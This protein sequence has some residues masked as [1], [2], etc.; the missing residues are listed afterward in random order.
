MWSEIR[1]NYLPECREVIECA[2]NNEPPQGKPCGIF[3]VG[4][5]W[6]GGSIDRKFIIPS[7]LIP[8]PY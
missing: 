4:L 8:F 5:Y 1:L 2:I 6:N 7:G 3:S